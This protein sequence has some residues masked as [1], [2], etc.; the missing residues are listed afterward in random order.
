MHAVTLALSLHLLV[1]SFLSGRVYKTQ[2]RPDKAL[3]QCEKS[4]QL[5]RGCSQPQKMISVYRDMA[6]V[7]QAR[8]RSDRAMEHL[9]KASGLGPHVRRCSMKR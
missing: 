5:L 1:C 6:A 9:S 7:E 4:L 2:K 8:G 3:G